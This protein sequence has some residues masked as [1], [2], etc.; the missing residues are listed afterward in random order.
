MKTFQ[1]IYFFFF[2][3]PLKKNMSITPLTKAEKE[4]VKSLK[5]DLDKIKTG[6]N[7]P[8]DYKLWDIQLDK[9]S[10]DP[11]LDVLLVKFLRAR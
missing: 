11:K 10:T 1:T 2:F 8:S 6:A 3:L 5:A 9:D 7:I 4:A